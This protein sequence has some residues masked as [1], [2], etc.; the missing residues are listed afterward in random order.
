MN[1]LTNFTTLQ[2]D[3]SMVDVDVD[4]AAAKQPSEYESINITRSL[5]C[6]LTHHQQTPLI[7]STNTP[8]PPTQ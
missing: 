1:S 4:V 6:S 5:A 3:I 2:L 8:H 7:V